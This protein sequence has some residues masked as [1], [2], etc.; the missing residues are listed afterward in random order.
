[1]KNVDRR[2]MTRASR[3]RR[4]FFGSEGRNLNR[5]FAGK[6]PATGRGRLTLKISILALVIGVLVGPGW[7]RPVAVAARPI[8]SSDETPADNPPTKTEFTI[9]T[10]NSQS[11][12]CT[13]GP[14][15]NFWFCETGPSKIG[16]MTS[17]GVFTEFLL[18]AGA[19]PYG[20]VT[21][22][23]DALWFTEQLANKIGR[24]DVSGNLKE[25]PVPTPSSGPKGIATGPDDALWFTEQLANKI[26]RVTTSGTFSEFNIPT[27]GTNPF[28]ICPGPDGNMWFTES[29]GGQL[30][31]VTPGGNVTEIDIPTVNPGPA[32][33]APGPDGNL[34]FTEYLASKIGRATPQGKITEFPLS[35]PNSLPFGIVP[36]PN[37]NM[38]FT[39]QGTGQVMQ[40]TPGD[41]PVFIPVVPFG[42]AT[43]IST[44]LVNPRV[45]SDNFMDLIFACLN[46]DNNTVGAVTL[47]G[48][49]KGYQGGYTGQLSLAT[50]SGL[51]TG[52]SPAGYVNLQITP[53]SPAILNG[54]ILFLQPGNVSSLTLNLGSQN[55]TVPPPG[56]LTGTTIVQ[57]PPQTFQPPATTTNKPV[58]KFN[59]VIEDRRYSTIFAFD[60]TF[61]HF[62]DKKTVPPG[63][64]ATNKVTTTVSP[65]ATLTPGV[66]NIFPVTNLVPSPTGGYVPLGLPPGSAIQV[67]LP[68]G[69]SAPNWD[70]NNPS[71]FTFILSNT[72]HLLA[73][74]LSPADAG[75]YTF[76][77]VAQTGDLINIS[78]FAVT[79]G[80]PDFSLGFDQST[81]NGQAGTKVRVTVNINRTGGFGGNVTVTPPDPSGGIRA[82]P[83]DPVT[84]T[85]TSATFK[86]KIGGGAASGPHQIVFKGTDDSGRERDVT[87][88]L[89]VQ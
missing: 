36:A 18:T 33:I 11:F 19:G 73:E 81:V 59:A 68:G 37:G 89:V 38:M 43:G 34:W 29:S 41:N 82:K 87:L 69:P 6:T 13:S 5:A 45:D 55:L 32:G 21:G 77:V 66:I 49:V 52:G 1:M 17:T 83:P 20:P 70:P 84:T 16:R 53:G 61:R 25:F 3:V 44:P 28:L 46:P 64:T 54:S 42:S 39:Q 65:G 7:P 78:S 79:P 24:M 23:D 30:G 40:F 86:L 56:A 80:G 22:A 50:D 63:S 4:P 75:D 15:G 26:G 2:E 88:T 72:S 58:F 60:P 74:R 76:A 14:D 8:A 51:P 12:Q 67:T 62:A 35:N 9:P 57:L 47:P 27:P 71:G 31:K 10:P 85:D 48:A